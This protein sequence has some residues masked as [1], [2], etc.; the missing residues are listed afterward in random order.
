M[1]LDKTKEKLSVKH[2]ERKV[3]LQ[4]KKNSLKSIMKKE[5]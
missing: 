1:D 3:K 4:E 5:N 2:D